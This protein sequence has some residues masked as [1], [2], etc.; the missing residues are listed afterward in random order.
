MGI[1]K[2]FK[3]LILGDESE[4]PE[5][6][7]L[8]RQL[9]KIRADELDL[10]AETR[11]QLE[12]E[13]RPALEGHNFEHGFRLGAQLLKE[14]KFQQAIYVYRKLAERYPDKRQDCEAQVGMVYY[15]M[16]K[17]AKAIESYI[18]AR[19]HGADESWM[20]ESIWE[21]CETQAHRIEDPL[22]QRESLELYLRICP[23]G[24]HRHQAETELQNLPRQN[25]A[26]SGAQG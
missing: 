8:A 24:E 9:K 2:F 23:T 10:P 22:R 1:R 19:V 20:D 12:E 5:S 25:S 6:D 18:A 14:R 26:A 13:L 17:Y 11:A 4:H 3:E 15:C 7:K 16:G 21:A